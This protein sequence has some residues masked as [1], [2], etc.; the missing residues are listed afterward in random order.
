MAFMC[1]DF[2]K[3]VDGVFEREIPDDVVA[4]SFNI[5]DDGRR[6]WSVEVV[7]TA[8]FDK[9]GEDWACDEA[10]D[11]ETRDA[12]FSWEEK[13]NWKNVASAVAEAVRKYLEAGRC[14]D[15]LKTLRGVASGFVDGDL[16]LVYVKE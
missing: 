4:L 12:P 13:T 14:A 2:A 6:R 11:F 8:S 15:K 5:Y 1:D 7:G 3:W 9:D 10:T 16:K